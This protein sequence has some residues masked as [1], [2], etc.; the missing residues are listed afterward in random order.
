MFDIPEDLKDFLDPL[1]LRKKIPQ[2]INLPEFAAT[3]LRLLTELLRAVTETNRQLVKL[4]EEAVRMREEIRM[5]RR[6][7]YGEEKG[8]EGSSGRNS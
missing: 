8:D 1:K 7:L 5:L 2:L 3:L 6:E 4:N